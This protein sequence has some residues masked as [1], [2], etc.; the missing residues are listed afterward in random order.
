MLI[1]RRF[2]LGGIATFANAPLWGRGPTSYPK[3]DREMMVPVEGG[4]V[5]VRV[6]GDLKGP[7]PPIIF[8]HG[9]PGGNHSDFLDALPLA[10]ERAVIMYDRLDSGNS[11]H[12]MTPVNWAAPRFVDE[13]NLVK[14]TLQVGQ[15]HVCGLNWGGTLALEYGARRP[16]GLTSLILAS[17]LISTKSWIADTNVL[18]TQ[19]PVSVQAELKICDTRPNDARCTAATKFFSANFTDREPPSDVR[20]TY[21]A[22]MGQREFG[23]QLYETMWGKRPMS[24][25]ARSG[26]A[27]DC[28]IRP[29][30]VHGHGAF[31]RLRHD[32]S[33]NLPRRQALIGG[34]ATR[35]HGLQTKESPEG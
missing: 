11:D 2:F 18:R 6:N 35:A 13:V 8:I 15:W 21:R 24:A 30:A 17:P 31:A 22:M 20:K 23:D 7:K 4:R 28:R 33:R 12:P 29:E 5:Y 26:H 34:V 9:G 14:Y 10:D 25:W 3:P 32:P 27:R 19:L 1:D 16:V